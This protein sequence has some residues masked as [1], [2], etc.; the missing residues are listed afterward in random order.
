[1][2]IRF[3]VFLLHLYSSQ[4]FSSQMLSNL[5]ETCATLDQLGY[6]R[7]DAK[8]TALQTK[9]KKNYQTMTQLPNGTILS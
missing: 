1:M 4:M 6:L 8:G 9:P 3:L 2:K 7:N 5:S